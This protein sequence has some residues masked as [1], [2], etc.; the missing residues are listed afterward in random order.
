MKKEIVGGE[1]MLPFV[2]KHLKAFKKEYSLIE[3]SKPQNII[4]IARKGPRLCEVFSVLGFED[5]E[6]TKIVSDRAI[7]FISKGDMENKLYCVFDDVV[8]YGSTMNDV[9]KDLEIRGARTKAFSLAYDVDR[10]KLDVKREIELHT[11]EMANFC[12]EIATS[13]TLLGKPYDI[14]HPI[15]SISLLKGSNTEK[16]IKN[17]RRI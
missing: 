3:N 10:A 11:D 6:L 17:S 12:S 5:F 7:P 8:I 13:F 2:E 1:N 16:G 14:D 9:I 4:A 15:L